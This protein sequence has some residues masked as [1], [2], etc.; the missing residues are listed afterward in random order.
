MK[1]GYHNVLLR[2]RVLLPALLLFC[3]PTGAGAVEA[4]SELLDLA[5]RVEYGFYTHETR[6]IETARAGL[7]RLPGS[8]ALEAY[9]EG[10]AA[11]RSALLRG[12]DGGRGLG[13][14]LSDCKDW[15]RNAAADKTIAG[16]AWILVAACA[17]V[18]L[19]YG[20]GMSRT[21]QNQLEEALAEAYAL[22]SDNPRILL[23]GAWA[24]SQR[25][26]REEPELQEI[27]RERLEQ[28]L[29]L[30]ALRTHQPFGQPEWGEAEALA[31]LGEISF[32]RGD[33]RTARDFDER[34]LLLAPDYHFALALQK[35]VLSAR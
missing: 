20:A 7:A 22:D 14:L 1:A 29:E 27:A 33:Y 12:A 10:L 35:R 23:V 17:A 3:G 6:A 8:G 19:E 13:D 16:E 31:H 15:G 5:S 32:E 2:Y 4:S 21:N 30:F 18:G 28:A 34:S 25:P 11:Y 26:A 9:Y 24:I